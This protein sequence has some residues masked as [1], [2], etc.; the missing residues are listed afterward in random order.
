MN[1]IEPEVPGMQGQVF[2]LVQ[3]WTRFI[4]EFK[5]P[6]SEKQALSELREIQQWEGESAWEYS[7]KFKD[8]IGRLAHPIHEE[9]QREWYIQGLLPLTQ[10][11]LTQQWII[12]LTDALEQSMKIEAMVGYPRSLRVT[13]PLADVNL[14][15]LQ[16]KISML[17]ENI[18][19]PMI[20]K[21]GRPQ[22]WCTRCYIEGHLENKC[23]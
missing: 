21:P 7:Q 12:T 10:I 20:P 18:Q 11:L 3:V 6:Q 9:H 14:A 23:P 16:G 4:A 13:R 17:T 19:D 15:Q 1:I 5:L 22:V 8:A 2:T